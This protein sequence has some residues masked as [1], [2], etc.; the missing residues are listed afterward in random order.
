MADFF[1]D[2]RPRPDQA[3]LTANHIPQLRQLIEAASA[4]KAPEARDAGI[5]AKL[6]SARPFVGGLR[7]LI[8]VLMKNFIGIDDHRPEFPGIE[9]ASTAADAP[10]GIE[11]WTGR[12][13]GNRSGNQ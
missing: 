11:D 1:T 8:E 10:V 3:H 9:L 13:E 12:I 6:L 5:I 4:K 7:I 2:D